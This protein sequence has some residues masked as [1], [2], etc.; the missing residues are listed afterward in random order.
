MH[1]SP[2]LVNEDVIALTFLAVHADGD[3][4][5]LED[6]DELEFRKLAPLVGIHDLG[7][8]I[9]DGVLPGTDAEL[10]MHGVRKF[11]SGDS[12]TSQ[13]ITATRYKSPRRIDKY[14]LSIVCT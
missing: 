1:R 12:G 7:G 6:A 5:C 4:V 2:K 13:S 8:R 3:A 9:C 11:P 10:R 14:V